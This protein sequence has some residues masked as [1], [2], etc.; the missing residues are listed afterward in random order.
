M[1]DAIRSFGSELKTKGG[2]GLLFYAGHGVQAHGENYLLPIGER[3]SS[4]D[5]LK[6]AG[7]I[8]GRGGRRHVG[9]AQRPQHRHPRRLP[10][11]SAGG[12]S[13]A[14]RGCRASI[15]ARACSCR[16][17][18]RRARSRWTATAA[19]APTPSISR[20]RS[21]RANLTLE[22][23]FK[24][25]L[26]GVYQETG[27]QQQPWISSSFFGEFVF[28][29]QA[30]PPG[31]DRGAG[32]AAIVAPLAPEQQAAVTSRRARRP[33]LSRQAL[34]LGGLYLVEG[35]NPNGSRYRGMVAL[36]RPAISTASPGGSSGRCSPA[37]ASLPAACWW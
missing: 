24:R 18:P 34:D 10:R 21:Q 6:A 30:Q 13:G 7:V 37:S 29:P 33:A 35:T 2:V 20:A 19:T 17:R 22:D 36:T 16:S 14:T 27:G 31:A 8:G 28:R 9:G 11:Q 1:K 15:R 3:P 12:G 32:G 4:E 26:K 25:T 23:T 5:G